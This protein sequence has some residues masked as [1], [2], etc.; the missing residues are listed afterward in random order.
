MRQQERPFYPLS[1]LSS[2]PPSSPSLLDDSYLPPSP[3]APLW[4]PQEEDVFLIGVFL[5]SGGKMATS[6]EEEVTRCFY[7]SPLFILPL[8]LPHPLFIYP[9]PPALIPK[10]GRGGREGGQQNS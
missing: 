10:A 7:L 5:F 1:H 8:P 9:H 2:P 6:T 4:R 3:P